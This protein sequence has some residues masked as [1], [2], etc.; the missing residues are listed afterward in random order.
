MDSQAILDKWRNEIDISQYNV[1]TN[2]CS[3]VAKKLLLTGSKDYLINKKL[4]FDQRLQM[5][6]NTINLAR[7]IKMITWEGNNNSNRKQ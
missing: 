3:A 4:R 1:F 7:E 5:P 6:T 2:N